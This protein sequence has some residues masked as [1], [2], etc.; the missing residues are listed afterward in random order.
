MT[1]VE[2]HVKRPVIFT[3]H[4][5]PDIFASVKVSGTKRSAK[6]TNRFTCTSAKYMLHICYIYVTHMY[7]IHVVFMQHES[8]SYICHNEYDTLS[9]F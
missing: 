5:D 1:F 4:L 6:I 9:Y 2:V 3:D 7:H 8:Q